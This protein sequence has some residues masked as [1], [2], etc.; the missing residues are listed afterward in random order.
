M[1][2]YFFWTTI[3][4]NESEIGRDRRRETGLVGFGNGIF[5]LSQVYEYVF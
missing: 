5:K 1:S 3:D 2:C 4:M